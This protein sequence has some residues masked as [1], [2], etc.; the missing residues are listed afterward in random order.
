MFSEL[1][2]I[3]IS[4]LR[5]AGV[6]LGVI[7]MVAVA[8]QVRHRTWSRAQVLLWA[9]ISV[10]LVLVS[11]FPILV[12]FVLGPFAMS[13]GEG[14]PRIVGLLVVAV[15]FATSASWGRC[16]RPTC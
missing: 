4:P 8:R 14:F 1:G 12:S 7:F 13:E 11:S 5:M 2:S 16:R 6:V 10:G 15:I 9:G 3:E